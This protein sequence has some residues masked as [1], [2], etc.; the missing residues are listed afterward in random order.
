MPTLM[1][2][3][4]Q[5]GPRVFVPPT[6]HV[7]HPSGPIP[8]MQ[9]SFRPVNEDSFSRGCTL[10]PRGSFK[11]VVHTTFAPPTSKSECGDHGWS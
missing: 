10:S 7:A 9:Q 3:V 5:A 2:G 1:H 6:I 8:F 11:E 4:H